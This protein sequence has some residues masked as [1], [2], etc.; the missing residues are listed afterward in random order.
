MIESNPQNS[1]AAVESQWA[2][3]RGAGTWGTYTRD[4]A[5]AASQ[6]QN[7]KWKALYTK[8]WR[9]PV[10]SAV[11]LILIASQ[12]FWVRQMRRWGTSLIR[13]AAWRRRVSIAGLV[14]YL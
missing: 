9:F 5:S 13:S 10:A 1:S 14:C 3:T 6:H 7:A 12:I 2:R 8:R 11:V 4:A